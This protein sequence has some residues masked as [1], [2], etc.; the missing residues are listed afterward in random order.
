MSFLCTAP[1]IH[2]NNVNCFS[3]LADAHNTQAH[4]TRGIT[5]QMHNVL[6]SVH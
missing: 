5:A 4:I 1:P 2:M 3:T 6:L